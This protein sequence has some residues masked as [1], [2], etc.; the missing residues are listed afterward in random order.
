MNA[1]ELWLVSYLANTLWMVPLVFAAAWAAARIAQKT[2]PYPVHRIWVVAIVTETLL[3]AMQLHIFN[4]EILRLFGLSKTSPPVHGRMAIE[5]SAFTVG[6]EG[7]LI[8]SHDALAAIA[9]IY[10]AGL[11]YFA[12]KLAY[13]L[14]KTHRIATRANALCEGCVEDRWRSL[15]SVL[16]ID[17]A[18]AESAEIPG[19]VTVG[20]QRKLLLLPRGFVKHTTDEDLNAVMAHECAH[21][22]RQDFLKNVLYS[23]ISLPCA[24]HPFLWLTQARLSES[25]EMICDAIA[26]A[27]LDGP[28]TYARSLLRLASAMVERP[29]VNIHAIGIFDANH[30]ERRI[31]RLTVGTA[32]SGRVL[33]TLTFVA[34]AAIG[35][36]TCAS[37]LTLRTEIGTEANGLTGRPMAKEEAHPSMPVLISS[38]IP[39]Y[40]AKGKEAH[41]SGICLVGLT[42][43]Q[44]GVPQDVHIIRSLRPDFDQNAME[45]VREYRFKPALSDGRPV[46]RQIKVE[47]KFAYF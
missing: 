34:C 15:T 32:S 43:D 31:M 5:L 3:P 23:L 35:F 41:L 45:A 10:I 28:R 30:F 18:I 38:K 40:P 22:V 2:G 8:F 19:P 33:R 29:Q 12:T 25:R 46:S 37:A 47:V 7:K 11:T 6:R 27:M 9:A 14:W 4:S 42:V 39:E 16:G 26:A 17:A 44:Q 21:M 36:G 13:S 1:L 24:F 20:A